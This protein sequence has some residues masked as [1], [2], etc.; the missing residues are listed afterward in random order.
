MKKKKLNVFPKK[1][2]FRDYYFD[3]DLKWRLQKTNWENVYREV[4]EI[5]NE[6]TFVVFSKKI[7]ICCEKCFFAHLSTDGWQMKFYSK[8]NRECLEEYFIVCNFQCTNLLD[9]TSNKPV[10]VLISV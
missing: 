1:A 9:E 10:D 3:F 2:F 6:T 8:A 5:M 4:T 7:V